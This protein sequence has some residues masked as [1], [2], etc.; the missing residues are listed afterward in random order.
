V[1]HVL[2]GHEKNVPAL[3]VYNDAAGQPCIASGGYDGGLRWYP[4][5]LCTSKMPSR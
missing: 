1:L 3:A 4:C 2:E 5:T